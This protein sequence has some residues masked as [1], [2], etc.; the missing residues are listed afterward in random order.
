MHKVAN[1]W[2]IA[3][4]QAANRAPRTSYIVSSPRLLLSLSLTIV[5]TIARIAESIRV[6]R[7][8]PRNTGDEAFKSNISLASLASSRLAAPRF[9]SQNRWKLSGSG[10]NFKADADFRNGQE[11]RGR[12]S[13][14]SVSGRLSRGRRT[15]GRGEPPA[16]FRVLELKRSLGSRFTRDFY[17]RP[18][19][20]SEITF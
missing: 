4:R 8:V 3:T 6:S 14:P 20:W 12:K 15:P 11:E 5:R 18:N 16:K 13:A 1:R 10:S 9:A 19:S 2:E 7:A 17:T